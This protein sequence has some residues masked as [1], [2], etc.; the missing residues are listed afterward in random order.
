MSRPAAVVFSISCLALAAGC[1]GEEG[2]TLPDSSTI[3]AA[4]DVVE[5][6]TAGGGGTPSLEIR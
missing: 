1:G 4:P 3:P 2:V 6:E 5:E